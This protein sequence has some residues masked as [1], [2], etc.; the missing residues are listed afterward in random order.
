MMG[1]RNVYAYLARKRKAGP[2]NPDVRR[3][4]VFDRINSYDDEQLASLV[5][6]QSVRS[7]SLDSTVRVLVPGPFL[8]E[9]GRVVVVEPNVD[10]VLIFG[11][12][13]EHHASGLPVY[14]TTN[15]L[16]AA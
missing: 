3:P 15:E 7:F 1:K 11:V 5:A 10:G 2:H 4:D 8:Q 12:V 13:F 9:Q 16:E 14:F 6:R